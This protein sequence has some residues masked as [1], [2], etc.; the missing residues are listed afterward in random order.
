MQFY[1]IVSVSAP[2]AVIFGPP[3]QEQGTLTKELASWLRL[4]RSRQASLQSVDYENK[5][6][7]YCISSQLQLFITGNSWEIK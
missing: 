7:M 6:K 2:S 3:D 5:A 4:S 1:K